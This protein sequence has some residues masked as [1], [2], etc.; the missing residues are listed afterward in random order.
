[1]RAI[2]KRV[3]AEPRADDGESGAALGGAKYDAKDAKDAK[4]EANAKNERERDVLTPTPAERAQGMMAIVSD[5]TNP[6]RRW[7]VFRAGQIES[8]EN[9][10]ESWTDVS[11]T[12]TATGTGV[13]TTTAVAPATPATALSAGAAESFTVATPFSDSAS[14]APGVCWVVGAKGIVWHKAPAQPWQL[15]HV[16][17]S[18][19]LTA[20][21]AT[22]A[23]DAIVTTASGQ[24]FRTTDAGKTW[25][26]VPP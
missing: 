21:T 12:G 26:R 8:S 23:R 17:S 5:P 2:A 10:G 11:I 15:Q 20:V 25:S 16:P 18:D 14:P 19:N 6:A 13:A 1:A 4:K 24:R 7:R 3:P 9:A 22:T